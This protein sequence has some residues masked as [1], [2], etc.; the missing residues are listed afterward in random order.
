MHNFSYP[1][2]RQ[3]MAKKATG[4][5]RK[6]AS[7][8]SGAKKSVI[9]KKVKKKGLIKK[10]TV[11]KKAVAKKTTKKKSGKKAAARQIKIPPK[12]SVPK[13]TVTVEPGPPRT[14]IPPVEEPVRN[15]EAL[16]TVTHYYSHLGVAIVQINKSTLS[17]GDL[18]RIAGNTTDFTQPVESMEYEHRHID[19]AGA[20]QSVGIK[21]KDH[22]RQ[23]DIVYRVK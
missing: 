9:K 4:T 13:E 6:K 21:V 12:P 19:S 5:T 18:I 8:K 22:A 7:R 16:G 14:G 15:E 1:Q 20:G 11:K 10:K 17:T 3:R 2:R 23:H